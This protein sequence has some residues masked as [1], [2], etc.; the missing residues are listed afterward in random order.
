MKRL[1]EIAC[2][3]EIVRLN[4]IRLCLWENLMQS[5]LHLMQSHTAEWDARVIEE[6]SIFCCGNPV[7]LVQQGIML[8]DPTSS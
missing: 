5:Q 7:D 3:T 4:A 2:L 6:E 1:I 8:H